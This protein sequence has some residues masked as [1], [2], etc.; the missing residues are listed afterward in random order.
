VTARCLCQDDRVNQDDRQKF[1][2]I[3]HAHARTIDLCEACAT[4]TRD[5][6]AE[7]RRGGMPRR[8]DLGKTVAESERVLADLAG[9]RTVDR[10]IELKSGSR[11]EPADTMK[12]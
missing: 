7:V 3:L 5:L 10:D 6:A 1:L 11:L 2:T 4:T 9:G 8:E 12:G